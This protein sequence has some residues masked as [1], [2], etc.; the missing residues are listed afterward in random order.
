[1]AVL[2]KKKRCSGKLIAMY[3][4]DKTCISA[5]VLF[6]FAKVALFYCFEKICS[7]NT[8]LPNILTFFV[9]VFHKLHFIII[10]LKRYSV[11]KKLI[12]ATIRNF[13]ANISYFLELHL[14]SNNVIENF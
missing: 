14:Y 6:C 9:L 1:V 2:I 4:K 3:N 5:L 12:T 13:L 11:K 8:L 10:I 7:E